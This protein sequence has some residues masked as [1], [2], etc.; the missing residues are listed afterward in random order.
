MLVSNYEGK[1][2]EDR[3][4]NERRKENK[5]VNAE[6]RKQERRNRKNISSQI[7]GFYL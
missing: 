4:K 6:K 2:F 3:R 7:N 1:I 5:E